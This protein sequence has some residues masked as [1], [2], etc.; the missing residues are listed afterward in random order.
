[1]SNRIKLKRNSS[2]DFDAATLPSGLHY[3]ELGFQNYTKKLFIGRCT[4]NSQA[5]SG[6]ETTHLPLLS[7][8]S[9]ATNGGI[10]T[11]IASGVTDNS[12][13]LTLDIND[14]SSAVIASG[15]MIAFSDEGTT[16]DPTKR[17][18]IDDIATLFAGAGMTA[19]SAVMNV[20]AGTGIAVAA[21]AVAVS[22]QQSGI[23]S[24]TN[25]S[26]V[27]GRDEDNQ[28]K[29]STD[30]QI[31]FRVAGADGVTF[32]ASGEI[33][34]TELDISGAADIGGALTA[35]SLSI[36]I[37]NAT[38]SLRTPLIEYTDG[39]DAISIAANGA[40]TIAT[41][42]TITSGGLTVS[43][44]ASSF[45]ANVA[46]KASGG[47]TLQLNTSTTDVD[48][49]GIIGRLNFSAP[50]ESAGT[51]AVALAASI[52]AKAAA[53][54]TASVNK[55]DIIFYVGESGTAAEAMKIGWDKK[56]TVKGDLQVDGTTT[57]VN[58][59]T[60]T[61]D[62]PIFTLGG[63]GA[64]LDDAKDRGIEF[65]WNSGGAKVGFFGMDDGDNTFMYIPDASVSSE[66]YSGT[67]GNAKFG[68]VAATA[69]TGATIDCG[70]F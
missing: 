38:T 26:L 20:I 18:S 4:A 57:T 17:E 39:T 45:L 23:T 8:L 27:T 49:D 32:K 2:A 13:T 41:G 52:V 65:K 14:L 5:D 56:V 40:L 47:T 60:V 42:A 12:V 44:G 24:I 63:D 36:P 6:A 33:E 37:V 61:I 58:S 66:A 55:T 46:I 69:I 28:I 21:D 10:A 53:D 51:D 68:S 19:S 50:D 9:S 54:F 25:T 11:T 64:G 59:T 70:T 62:D 16:D 34:A 30:N 48:E 15:D 35:G 7:D 31:I 1:M 67:L 43:A 22:A 29:Y 3:G